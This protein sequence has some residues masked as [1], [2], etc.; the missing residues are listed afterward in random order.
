MGQVTWPR[1]FRRRFII[2]RLGRAMI[3]MYTKFEVSAITC[4]EEMKGNAKCKNSRYESPFGGLGITHRVYLWLDGKHIVDFQLAIIELLLL[5]LMA[6]ALLSEIGRNWHFLKGW[7][8]LSTNI[9]GKEEWSTNDSWRQKTSHWD[10]TWQNHSKPLHCKQI[11]NLLTATGFFQW[12][13]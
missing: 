13:V 5:A 6:A 4:N 7:V 1:P 12:P 8:S 11:T 3:N 9:R 10:I 2:C